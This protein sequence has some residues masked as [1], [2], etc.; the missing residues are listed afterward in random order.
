M[1]F[2][3]VDFHLG[4]FIVYLFYFIL[5]TLYD[6]VWILIHENLQFDLE[7]PLMLLSFYFIFFL[8]LNLLRILFYFI[9]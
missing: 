9:L 6:F 2:Y 3:D 4:I 5:V 8:C 1:G 7:P